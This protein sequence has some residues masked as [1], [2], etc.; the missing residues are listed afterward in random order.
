MNRKVKNIVEPSLKK[1]NLSII[2]ILAVAAIVGFFWW[3]SVLLP[4]DPNNTTSQ[5]FIV[6]KGENLSSTSIRLQEADLVRSSLAFKILVLSKGM[7]DKIQAGSFVLNPSLTGQQI[8]EALTHGTA[9][10]W[11][12]FPEGWRSQ[13]YGQR[14]TANLTEFDYQDWLVLTKDL[15]GQ[16]FPDTYL[17]P[18][19]AT[20]GAVI[21]FLTN[22]FEKKFSGE[23]QKAKNN[24]LTENQVL[25]I[26]SLVEREAR[27]DEDRAVV[28]GIIIKRLENDWPLQIDASVQYLAGDQNDWWPIVTKQELNIDSPYNT[29]KY[30]G[31]PPGPICNPGLSSIRAVLY[32]TTTDYWFY[33]SDNQGKMHYARTIEGHNDNISRYLR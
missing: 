19:Q 13:E 11:L 22:N 12:T 2:L 31:L 8:A 25:T 18:K 29:Y 17:L 20:A 24:D 1:F 16:L 10:I 9:D 21:S 15:E 27:H 32:P 30:K 33:L 26:A 7:S 6:K 3:R 14:L 23:F 28:A 5:T 4:V